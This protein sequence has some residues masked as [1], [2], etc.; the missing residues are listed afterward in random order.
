MPLIFK[1]KSRVNA[2]VN[3]DASVDVEVRI[4]PHFRKS[5]LVVPCRVKLR[6][7]EHEAGNYERRLLQTVM[8]STEVAERKNSED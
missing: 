3:R 7:V 8:V 4:K 2:M 6:M 5:K 1:Q